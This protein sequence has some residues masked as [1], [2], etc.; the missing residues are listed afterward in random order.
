MPETTTK[1]QLQDLLAR[2]V[3]R[4]NYEELV[5][6]VIGRLRE[7]GCGDVE[8][9]SIVEEHVTFNLPPELRRDLPS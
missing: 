8:E 3:D 2:P 1:Q 4:T 6:G 5:R 9:V 7:L